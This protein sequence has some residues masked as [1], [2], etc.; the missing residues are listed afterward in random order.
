M[1]SEILQPDYH[2]TEQP[3][4]DEAWTLLTAQPVVPLEEVV[5][6]P[7]RR[8]TLKLVGLFATALILGAVSALLAIKF[9]R[10]QVVLTVES[11][12]VA[13]QP[14]A[15]PSE[16]VAKTT[17]EPENVPTVAPAPENAPKVVAVVT[18]KAK[19]QS[20]VEAKPST[21][22]A[23]TPARKE[24]ASSSEDEPRAQLV[25]EFRGGWEERRARR[26]ARRGRNERAGR[27]GRDLRRIDEIFE[28][29]RP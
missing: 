16:V 6:K 28:G 17:P 19:V 1:E 21:N 25:D 9:E 18:E 29:Q 24:K 12:S 26:A 5:S 22:V 15:T 4:F 14:Q 11:S 13:E 7:K 3:H 8:R 10:R 23:K 2:S 27:R 20:R